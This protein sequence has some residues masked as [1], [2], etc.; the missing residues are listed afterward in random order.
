MKTVLSLL[1]IITFSNI[2]IAQ[3]TAIPDAIFEQSLIDLGYDTGS[4]DGIVLTSNIDTITDL[5][6]SSWGITDLSGI[7]DFAALEELSCDLYQLT[8]LDLSQNTALSSLICNNTQLTNLDLS[9]NTALSYLKCDDN[10]LTSLDLSQNTL[11]TVLSCR[12]NQLTNLDLSQNTALFNIDCSGNQLTSLD[13]SQNT[14]LLSLTC[15]S[16]QL[17]NLNVNQNSTLDYLHCFG[18]QLTSLDVSQNTV[19][20]ELHCFGNQLS[21][22]DVSH[23]TLLWNLRC[24]NNQLT[25]LDV[26]QNNALWHLR[27]ENN[28]LSCL[29]V[30]N[31]NNTNIA[32][33][34]AHQNPNLT[35][36]EVDDVAWSVINWQSIDTQT[37]FSTNC[38]NPCSIT[39]GIEE[40]SLSNLSLYPNPTTGNFTIE[41][42]ETLTEIKVALTNGLGQVVL[43]E[44]YTPTNF[45]NLDINAPKGIYFLQIESNAEVI[46]K[47]IVKE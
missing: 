2:T 17:T 22:L 46:T 3:T 39:T 44:N 31:G 7:E 14:T 12:Y 38:G 18:N 25:S 16:N 1:L 19:L 6:I 24:Y 30:K 40:S 28:Q 23:N 15:H 27:C 43:T 37:S 20:N 34:Y 45:I 21:T 10:Q 36:I 29:N 11:L 42:G 5:Y 35:C 33:F 32:V 47:K 41:F 13:L 4:P 8:S 26:S 9:Q